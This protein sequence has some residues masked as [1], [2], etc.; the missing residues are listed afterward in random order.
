M[1]GRTRVAVELHGGH[2]VAYDQ[3]GVTAGFLADIAG[4]VVPTVAAGGFDFGYFSTMNCGSARWDDPP[5]V[6]GR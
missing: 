2:F 5:T 3:L 6:F 1:G 4:G